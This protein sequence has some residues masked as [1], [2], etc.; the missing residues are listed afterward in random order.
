M[1]KNLSETTKRLDAQ[2]TDNETLV[3]LNMD[4]SDKITEL[5]S[6]MVSLQEQVQDR[7]ELLNSAENERSTLQ[8]ALQQ[9]KQLKA[10]FSE[11]QT[12]LIQTNNQ[13]AEALTELETLKHQLSQSK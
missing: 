3:K 4:Q 5:Q 6:G 7:K 1:E 8:R 12:A 9:N 13:R 11:L 2:V 10:Q